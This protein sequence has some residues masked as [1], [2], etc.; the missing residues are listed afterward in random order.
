MNRSLQRHGYG[1]LAM[2]VAVLATTAACDD[3]ATGPDGEAQM[4]VV[5]TDDPGSQTASAATL[6][7]AGF[8]PQDG[9]ASYSGEMT[10]EA[11]VQVSADGETYVDV[12]PPQQVSLELQ[13]TDGQASIHTDAGVDADSYSSVRLVLG[14]A[15][16]SIDAGSEIGTMVLDAALTLDIGSGS[17]VVIEKQATVE[18][19]SGS[20]TTLV[21]DMNSEAWI[22]EEN[23]Q[24]QAVAASE[25]ESATTVT[26]R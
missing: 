1:I 23:A 26:V 11:Q 12:G 4:T 19:E 6:V 24:A 5:A 25:I 9:Q 14:N 7:L 20:E 22:T 21:F 15:E 17:D 2:A 18:V 16:A 3:E 10:A 13:S 8:L